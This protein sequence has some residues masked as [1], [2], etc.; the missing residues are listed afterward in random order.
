MFNVFGV[1]ILMQISAESWGMCSRGQKTTGEN[2]LR[3]KDRRRW[4]HIMID[5]K[6]EK[7]EKNDEGRTAEDEWTM[8]G[9]NTMH[10]INQKR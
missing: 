1:S 3:R 9:I 6:K 8:F 7:V 5:V 4:E 2:N 10:P